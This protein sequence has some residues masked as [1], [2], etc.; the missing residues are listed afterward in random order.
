[1][2]NL[3]RSDGAAIA[4]GLIAVVLL[5]RTTSGHRRDEFLQAAR[6][7]IEQRRVRLELS[8]TPGIAVADPIVGD[9]DR[10]RDGTW[11]GEEQRAYV[12]DVLSALQLSV[13]GRSLAIEVIES[14][15][16][17]PAAVRTGEAVIEVRLTASLP[18]MSAG[19][20]YLSFTNAFRR[21]VSVYLT[22]ALAPED[23]RITITAQE[24]D[25]AQRT[26]TI[27]YTISSRASAMLPLWLCAPVAGAWL[28][29]R[30]RLLPAA[31]RPQM[32]QMTSTR[33]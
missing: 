13:D 7:G 19:T 6:I 24:R 28:I 22:N 9:I 23:D 30:R 1:M 20:H 10:D 8:L 11:S 16:P 31:S 27:A 14:T 25:P 5:S 21:D 4:L 29:L 17:Q 3:R 26:T 33:S 12:N 32:A 2:R 15:F 18:A